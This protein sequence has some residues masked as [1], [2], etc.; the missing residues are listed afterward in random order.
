MAEALRI[1][2]AQP[3]DLEAVAA[4]ARDCFGAS[5]WSRAQWQAIPP[6]RLLLAETPAHAC[7]GY[8]VLQWAADQAELESLAVRPAFRRQGVGQALLAAGLA[9]ARAAGVRQVFLELRESNAAAL[10]FYQR[11]G[12]RSTGRR[13]GYYHSPPEAALLLQ[14][15]LG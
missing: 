13:P 11:H 3:Q 4:L 2:P 12:F 14:A 7:A 8:V 5:A 15:E 1:R 10:A 9:A 6:L